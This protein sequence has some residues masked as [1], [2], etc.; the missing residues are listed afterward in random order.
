MYKASA[1]KNFELAASLRDRL[2]ALKH[3]AENNSIKIKT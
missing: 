2:K 3:I 1:E